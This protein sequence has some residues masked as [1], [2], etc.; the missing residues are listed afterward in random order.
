LFNKISDIDIITGVRNQDDKVLNWLYDNYFQSV[1]NHVLNN[2]GSDDDVSD[3]FQDAIIVLYNQITENK[4]RLTSDLKGYFFGIARNVWNSQLRKKQKTIELE[5]DLPD[6]EETEGQSDPTLERII[7]R[8]FQLLK[9]D[10][11]MVLNLFSDGLSYEEIAVKLN[12]KN[13]VYARRKKYLCKEALLELVKEDPEY[14][15]YLRFQK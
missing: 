10:Q 9:P 12:L 8:V 4:L 5:F 14:Q 2:S 11:Q 15:E 7:S 6:E 3:V 13:E 1:R